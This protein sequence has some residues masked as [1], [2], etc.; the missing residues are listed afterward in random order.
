MA[1]DTGTDSL[2]IPDEIVVLVW[3]TKTFS[4][5]PSLA[6]SNFDVSLNTQGNVTFI[7]ISLSTLM[8]I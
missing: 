1:V 2:E 4:Y 5:L 3:N 6:F 8:K 7:N